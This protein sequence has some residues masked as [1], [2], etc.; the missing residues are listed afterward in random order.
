MTRETKRAEE[1]QREVRRLIHENREI[2]EDNVTIRV[3]L[4][5]ELREPDVDG[6]NWVMTIFGNARGHM[7]LI[8]KVLADVKKRWNLK[9]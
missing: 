4:P 7:D 8:A 9:S 1:I 3:P 5:T 2:K 6:S